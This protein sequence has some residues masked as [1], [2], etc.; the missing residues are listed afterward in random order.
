[1]GGMRL[2]ADRIAAALK[3]LHFA[4]EPFWAA[5]GRQLAA[6]PVDEAAAAKLPLEE[7]GVPYEPPRPRVSPSC[8]FGTPPLPPR[9]AVCLPY[10][11]KSQPTPF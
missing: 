9:R 4:G 2:A 3:K 8:Q 10:V 5:A 6:V 1:M 7:E 11:T